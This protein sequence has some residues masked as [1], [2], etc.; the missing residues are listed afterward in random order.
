MMRR[1]WPDSSRSPR[2]RRPLSA[3]KSDLSG[4]SKKVLVSSVRADARRARGRQP[5]AHRSVVHTTFILASI[6]IG[7]ALTWASRPRVKS[8]HHKIH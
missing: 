8:T 2:R 1:S 5:L 7:I 4:V 3:L 6:S